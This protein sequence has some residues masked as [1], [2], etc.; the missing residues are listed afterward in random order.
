M[1]P[2]LD[3]YDLP[4]LHNQSPKYIHMSDVDYCQINLSV[5]IKSVLVFGRTTMRMQ[6]TALTGFR[7]TVILVPST[8]D[9]STKTTK[10]A[11]AVLLLTTSVK[12][13]LILT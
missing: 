9:L 2:S 6:F 5:V 4:F 1:L 8:S 10:A 3:S 13:R 11:I 7:W 12:R